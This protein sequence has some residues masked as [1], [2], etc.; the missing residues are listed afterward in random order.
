MAEVGSVAETVGQLDEPA[1]E[2]AGHERGE[3]PK[4]EPAARRIS[5]RWRWLAVAGA[6]A[7]GA[8]LAGTLLRSPAQGAQSVPGES[9]Q[10]AAPM[11]PTA[12]ATATPATTALAT[13]IPSAPEA[14]PSAAVAGAP[15]RGTGG[16]DARPTRPKPHRAAPNPTSRPAPAPKP[17]GQAAKTTARAVKESGAADKTGTVKI[18]AT[19]WAKVTVAGAGA[20]CDETPCTLTLP[21]GDHVL[22]LENP[23]A[24][25]RKER[26][27]RVVAGE[28]AIVRETLTR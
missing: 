17:A 6:L 28:T 26:A 9:A 10:P 13:E 22:A 18:S 5:R 16:P 15:G 25:L 12:A 19:P 4:A 27:V 2:R 1:G 8:L 3:S 14:K 21:A 24:G 11:P 7:G 20:G 23:V